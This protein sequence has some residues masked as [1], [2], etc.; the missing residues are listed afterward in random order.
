MIQGSEILGE[1]MTTGK[2]PTGKFLLSNFGFDPV[3]VLHDTM[4]LQDITLLCGY[5]V[6]DG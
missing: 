6:C 5:R 3:N 1:E 2:M 4:T